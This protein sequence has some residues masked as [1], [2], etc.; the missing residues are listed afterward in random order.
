M[1]SW[2]RLYERLEK[3]QASGKLRLKRFGKGAASSR[4]AKTP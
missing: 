3:A 4:A 1:R 2:M